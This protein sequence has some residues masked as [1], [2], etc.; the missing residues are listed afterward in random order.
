MDTARELVALI[1]PNGRPSDVVHIM[2]SS[3]RPSGPRWTLCGEPVTLGQ[4]LVW[5]IVGPNC[6]RCLRRTTQKGAPNDNQD[7]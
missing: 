1:G 4:E 5:G 2:R 3:P 7:H 6:Q